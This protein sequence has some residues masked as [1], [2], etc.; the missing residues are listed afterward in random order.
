MEKKEFYNNL[1]LDMK[2]LGIDIKE[3]QS[4]KFYEYM[5]LLIE[6]NNK[7][8][9]TAITK[10]EEII[11][12]HF[13]DSAVIS[14]Y[15]NNKDTII[16]VG[17]GAGFPGIPLKIL[18]NDIKITL[19]DSLNKRLVFLNE[20]ISKLEL[21]NV[22]IQHSR[23]E[24]AGSN[25]EYREKYDVAVSR[26]VAPLNILV[27]YLLP[28]IKIGGKAICMKGNSI[29]EEVQT[30]RKAIST[31]GGKVEKIESFVLPNTDINRSI[32]IIEKIK[33]TSSKYPRKAGIPSKN[34]IM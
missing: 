32:V 8:N 5:N 33:N 7:I 12:K 29:E 16:D 18:K 15:I 27:E 10:P 34:P 28:L 19:L 25:K 13:V 9:L 21:K 2:L 14:Q 31:L 30:A 24:E 23:A 6:W 20:V 17:T 4:E 3:E 22:K 11:K 1:M 26:A